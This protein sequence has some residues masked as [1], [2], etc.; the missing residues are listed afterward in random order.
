MPMQPRRLLWPRLL[1]LFQVTKRGCSS[2]FLGGMGEACCERRAKEKKEELEED[3]DVSPRAAWDE[4]AERVDGVD[5][6]EADDGEDA[7]RRDTLGRRR[8]EDEGSE[9]SSSACTSS[10]SSSCSSSSSSSSS[11]AVSSVSDTMPPSS[12]N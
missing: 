1:T 12:D 5:A 11:S 8:V 3:L 6:V 7:C 4:V 2:S 10:R 9:S